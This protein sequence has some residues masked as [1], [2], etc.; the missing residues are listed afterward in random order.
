MPTV[1]LTDPAPHTNA[2]AGVIATNNGNLRTLLNGGIDAANLLGTPSLASGEVPVWNGSQFVRSTVTRV[3]ATS[4]GSGTPDSTK[5]LRGDGSW[6]TLTIPSIGYATTLP[7]SPT[8][9][10]ESIL[11]DSLTVPTYQW[12]FRWNAGSANTDKWE[13]VGGTAAVTETP[14]ADLLNANAVYTTI[15]NAGPS[16]ALPRAGVYTVEVG[17]FPKQTANAH[18]YMSYDIGGTGAVDADAFEGDWG[19]G[20]NGTAGSFARTKSGLTAVTLT[21]KYKSLTG[22]TTFAKRWMRVTPVRV[23]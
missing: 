19:N 15:A 10:Q 14:N 17:C 21:A 5:Y 18:Y 20:G 6:Q 9:G 7:G 22:N 4:L 3:G 8:D 12:R 2:D 23:S 1:S 16:F 13:Y 11:V